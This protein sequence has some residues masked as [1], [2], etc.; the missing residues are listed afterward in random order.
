MK[1]KTVQDIVR[2]SWAATVFWTLVIVVSA[3]WNIYQSRDNTR[4]MALSHAILSLDKDLVYRRWAANHGGVYVP[5]TEQTPPNPYLAMMPERD[6]TTTTGKRLTL[7]NPAYMTRQVFELG[8]EQYGAKG[9]ITSLNPIRPE[10]G[11]DEWERSALLMFQRQQVRELHA[12][13][14]IDGQPYLRYMRAMVT[15]Q[16]CL[17][18]H[19][20]QGYKVDEVR[21]GI[22]VS[23]PLAS[24][25]RNE[26]Q[27]TLSIA[28]AHGGIWLLGVGFIQLKRKRLT[29]VLLREEAAGKAVEVMQR[30]LFQN[31]KMASVGQLA[32]GVAHEINNPMG[33]ISS[34]LGTLDKYLNRLSEFIASADQ[35]VARSGNHEAVHQLMEA[36]K[37][38]KI[39]HILDDIHQLIAES[40]DGAMRVRRIVQDLKSFSHVSEAE[41]AWVDLNETLETTINIAWNEIKYV[42]VLNRE[43]GELPRLRCF[44]QQL[45]Q[46]F[47]NLL[48][49][50]AHAIKGNGTITVK[51]WCDD[52][53][54]FVAISDT[55][56]GIA[57][58]HLERI[59]EPFFT[60]K[61]VGK[62]TGLGLSICY[63]I[64]K[65]HNGEI[66][67]ESTVGKG[68]TFT[69]R[70]PVAPADSD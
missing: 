52:S 15:E 68:T 67:V 27:L 65:K 48:V 22:S 21:G 28:V 30:Q 63:D 62:G 36:R 38:L 8:K 54:L 70:L 44:P 24:F 10:N 31:E 51:T 16:S 2:F 46:A 18:C 25:L 61:E 50:A 5:I 39:N 59:F 17:K 7:M 32:A 33:F 34:N 37:R 29:D 35:A 69:V 66:S 64:I 13:A 23:V 40:Q 14:P 6:V 12:L 45:N 43:F 1:N 56:A 41:T 53:N 60:T 42:A 4:K 3:F 19:G 55:G 20:H 49:N 26:Q 47:L 9:H 11:P 57:Q 58:E